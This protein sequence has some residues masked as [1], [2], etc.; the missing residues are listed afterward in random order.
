MTNHLL[1][2]G[3]TGQAMSGVLFA[4]MAQT[5]AAAPSSFHELTLI[6]RK[7]L[8]PESLSIDPGLGIGNWRVNNPVADLTI[9]SDVDRTIQQLVDATPINKI[10]LGAGISVNPDAG[11]ADVITNDRNRR[12]INQ[13]H[14][15]L[16]TGLNARNITARDTRICAIGSSLAHPDTLPF[17]EQLDNPADYISYARSKQALGDMITTLSMRRDCPKNTTFA[18]IRPGLIGFPGY[19]EDFPVRAETSGL[20]DIL[21]H[22]QALC[23]YTATFNAQDPDYQLVTPDSIATAVLGK[24]PPFQRDIP[25]MEVIDIY[26]LNMGLVQQGPDGKPQ[27]A[28][29]MEE[30]I[31]QLAL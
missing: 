17:L 11:G 27:W 3:A 7:P 16:L 19:P 28:G 14:I 20:N 4:A 9:L 2:T 24:T 29:P 26:D 8:E 1:F 6:T 31:A 12:A 18:V 5:H 13:A 25:R 30:N 10:C 23:A 21:R 22:G 15:N